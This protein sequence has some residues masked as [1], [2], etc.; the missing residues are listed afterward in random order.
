[1]YQSQKG[2][3]ENVGIHVLCVAGQSN[4]ELLVLVGSFPHHFI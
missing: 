4:F 3:F 2:M 1:M